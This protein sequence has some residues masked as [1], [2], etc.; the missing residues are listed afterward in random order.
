M[1]DFQKILKEAEKNTQISSD[2]IEKII[3][4]LIEAGKIALQY[5]NSPNLKVQIKEDQ[6]PVSNGDI[7]VSE[8][9]LKHLPSIIPPIPIIS[10]EAEKALSGNTFWLLD[11]IDNTYNYIRGNT[12]YT[13]NLGLIHNYHPVLGFIYYPSLKE[14]YYNNFQ[15]ECKLIKLEEVNSLASM[16]TIPVYPISSDHNNDGKIKVLVDDTPK[17]LDKVNSNSIFQIITQTSLR[18]KISAFFN[19][20]VDLYYRYK[21]TM[22]WDL[23][24]PHAM[25]SSIGGGIMDMFG[26]E[27]VY[28]KPTFLNGDVIIYNAHAKKYMKEILSNT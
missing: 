20:E 15:S 27:L 5:F 12:N 6:S 18:D 23:A 13:I 8:F 16:V 19:G 2:A 22:E 4:L 26:N 11:P 1:Q 3:N 24:S 9:M 14:I 7:S 28:G 25:L 17:N 21:P 10:E